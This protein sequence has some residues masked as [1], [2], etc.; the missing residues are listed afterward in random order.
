[1]QIIIAMFCDIL[2]GIKK[3]PFSGINFAGGIPDLFPE[4]LTGINSLLRFLYKLSK[5]YKIP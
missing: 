5:K 1:M 3:W 4:V 2:Q